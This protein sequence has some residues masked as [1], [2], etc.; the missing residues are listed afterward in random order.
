MP[1][2][3]TMNIG[4]LVLVLVVGVVL[5]WLFRSSR[6]AKDEIAINAEWQDPIKTQQIAHD[7]LVKQNENLMQQINQY[8]ASHEVSVNRTNELSASLKKALD[9]RDEMQ[10]QLKELGK[11]LQL[12]TAQRD[13]LNTAVDILD[14]QI[15]RS[16]DGLKEKDDEIFRQS[17]ELK[18]WL[19]RV[20]P[21]VE[22]YRARDKQVAKL[23]SEL[24]YASAR[25]EWLEEMA[26][27][28]QN[29]IEPVDAATLPDGLDASNEPHDDTSAPA[30]PELQD[31][32]HAAD[33]D[34][35]VEGE[36]DAD[37]EF[38]AMDDQLLSAD[39]SV[40]A[41]D[42]AAAEPDAD[43]AQGDDDKLFIEREDLDENAGSGDEKDDLK[44]IKGVG[45][46]IEKTLNDL[47]IFRFKQIAEMSEYDIDRVAQQLKG[48]RSRIYRGDWLGQARDLQYQKDNNPT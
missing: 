47:G 9:L 28:K 30:E 37:E 11:H 3:T 15:K 39:D 35:A 20:P 45:P 41:D 26:R 12:T 7:R 1:E 36:P 42:E 6:A 43:T 40:E 14:N 13:K 5:G 38:A 25:I 19:G 21:L 29:R 22:K 33:N 32:I 24:E 8:Q 46:A 44:Q 18:S 16:T 2:L 34:A 23:K 31:Q 4:L 10:R 48:F 27:S 17:R